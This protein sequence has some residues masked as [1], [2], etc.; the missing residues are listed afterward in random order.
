MKET[1]ELDTIRAIFNRSP[2]EK[3]SDILLNMTSTLAIDDKI[4]FII[5][6][7]ETMKYD[8]TQDLEDYLHYYIVY[9]YR[10]HK[11]NILLQDLN[12]KYGGKFVFS[13][14]HEVWK[15]HGLVI[16]FDYLLDRGMTLLISC[17]YHHR[18]YTDIPMDNIHNTIK[19]IVD[20]IGDFTIT[21]DTFDVFIKK[22]DSL[23][24]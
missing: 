4:K 7:I 24:N 23:L 10:K 5:D 13:I 17:S 22:V 12:E 16:S 2:V 15:Y 20:I 14:H 11:V 19:Q 9:S 21:E 3:K 18:A 6:V 8:E 1:L